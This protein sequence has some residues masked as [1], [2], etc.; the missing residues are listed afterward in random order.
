M[1]TAPVRREIP[2]AVRP[3]RSRQC[4]IR[5]ILRLCEESACPGSH[6]RGRCSRDTR[7]EVELHH[8]V[9]PLGPCFRLQRRVAQRCTADFVLPR[10]RV[11]VFVDG[12]F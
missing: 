10:H 6:L 2:A 5:L 4:G 3:D 11:A 9:H 12:C 7:P 8:A 1:V